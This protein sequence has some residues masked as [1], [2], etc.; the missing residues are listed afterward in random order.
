MNMDSKTLKAS[1]LLGFASLMLQ[2]S[3]LA[4]A[5]NSYK[6]ESAGM[7]LGLNEIAR[8][9]GVIWG[10]GFIDAD[11]LI[12]TVR[13]GDVTLLDLNTRTTQKISDTP[14]VHRVIGG[15]PFDTVASGGLF[16]V[17]VDPDF[18]SNQTIYLAYVKKTT[19]GHALAVARG[20]LNKSHLENTTDIFIANNDSE[21]AGRWGTRLAIDADGFLYVA[22]GDRRVGENAQNTLSHLGKIVRLNTDGS[23]PQD[24][25]FVDQDNFAPEIFSYGH[26]NPQGLAFHPNTA[27]LFEHEHGPDGGDEI[28]IITAG[29]N[30]GWPVI[31]YGVSRAGEQIGIGPKKAGMEQPFRYYEPGI[32][33]SGMQFYSGKRY[34]G[35]NG[36]LFIGSLNRMRLNRIV[37]DGLEVTAEEQLLTDWKERIRDIAQGPDG[38][39]YLA[40]GSG[41]I[42]RIE[43]IAN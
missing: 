19:N 13:R 35:W 2:V 23:V 15:G 20:Q 6:F 39:L 21:E 5:E 16:D 40:T 12:F 31:S 24:N 29:N 34:P 1:L 17:L 27:A 43:Q 11:T 26:R 10:L 9:D 22:V 41:R 38:R 25:P 36:N 14:T 8:V 28:N 7:H 37:L 42:V 4:A 30:Y 33:P 3:Q 18:Q 32:A